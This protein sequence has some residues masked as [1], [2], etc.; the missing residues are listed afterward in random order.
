MFGTFLIND[1]SLI[2]P[3]IIQ[4]STKSIAFARVFG[5]GGQ[6]LKPLLEQIRTK[7]DNL[8]LRNNKLGINSTR[9]DAAA[10]EAGLVLDSIDS[11]FGR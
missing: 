1:L 9:N 5:K 3:K 10:H 7:Y 8:V 6:L 11:Y 2:L 4:D